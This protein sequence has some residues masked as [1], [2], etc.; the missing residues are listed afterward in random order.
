MVVVVEI[1]VPIGM[2]LTKVIEI[3]DAKVGAKVDAKVDIILAVE[4]IIVEE[5]VETI[6]KIEETVM[7]VVIRAVKVVVGI[8]IVAVVVGAAVAVTIVVVMTIDKIGSQHIILKKRC[9][10]VK[11]RHM[12]VSR[13]NLKKQKML[14]LLLLQRRLRDEKTIYFLLKLLMT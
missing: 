12:K 13:S 4:V 2:G 14:K 5:V 7:L 11:F 6:M 8:T 1:I 3:V 9:E 10:S